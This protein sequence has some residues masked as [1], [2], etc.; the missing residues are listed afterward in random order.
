[1]V[2]EHSQ[3]SH[4]HNQELHS[5][6][7]MIAVVRGPELHVDQVDGGVCTAD[8][9]H[10]G[11]QHVPI[12]IHRSQT[13]KKKLQPRGWGLSDWFLSPSCKCCIAR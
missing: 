3:T 7:V 5:E 1:M 8:V 12:H 13:E 11:K 2:D 9:D 10:L 6:T 4:W